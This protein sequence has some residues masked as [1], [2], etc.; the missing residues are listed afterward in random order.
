MFRRGKSRTKR[1]LAP[2]IHEKKGIGRGGNHEGG[3]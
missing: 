1:N 3:D 2:S